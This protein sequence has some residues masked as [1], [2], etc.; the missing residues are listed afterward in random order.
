MQTKQLKQILCYGD[1]NTF[2]F[3]G[4]GMAD[5][6]FGGRYDKNTRW[7]GLLDRMLG[8]DYEIIEEGMC[9]R[10]T[11]FEDP[12]VPGRNGLTFLNVAVASHDPLDLV[13]VMLGT[14]DL[15]DIFPTT[16]QVCAEAMTRFVM[17]LKEILAASMNPSCK[18][19][20]VSPVHPTKNKYGS[21]CYDYNEKAI[22]LG[23][24]L[25]SLYQKVAEQ[26][27]CHFADADQWCAVDEN[28]GVH[29]NA[30]GHRAVAEK[31]AALIPTIVG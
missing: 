7:T 21:F 6:G 29:L 11:V 5:D 18:I 25:A 22:N 24:K 17:R 8:E 26:Q 15:R 28:D 19:L 23:P 13:I 9:G 16:E 20:I 2:G 27:G 10:T 14:N 30:E 3:D 12:L 1:S 4:R 31:L